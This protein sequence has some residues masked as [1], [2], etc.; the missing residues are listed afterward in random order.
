MNVL[1]ICFFKIRPSL[2]TSEEGLITFNIFGK[3]NHP[4]S[5]ILFS[6]YTDKV[7]LNLAFSWFNFDYNIIVQ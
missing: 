2:T 6:N 5:D 3:P 4:I 7:N 1:L